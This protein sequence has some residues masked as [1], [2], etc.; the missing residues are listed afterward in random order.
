MKNLIGVMLSLALVGCD[1][2]PSQFGGDCSEPE[3]CEEGLTCLTEFKDETVVE[4]G[5]CT[6][7]CIFPDECLDER[8]KVVNDC[9]SLCPEDQ[10]CLRWFVTGEKH[11]YESCQDDTDCRVDEGWRC[12]D[13][14]HNESAC[15]PPI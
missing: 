2:G 10:H 7:E 4:G 3:G 11:C 5:I 14:G 8:G 6:T 15:V 9:P 12:F 1:S 13:F